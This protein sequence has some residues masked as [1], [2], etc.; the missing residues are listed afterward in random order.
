M[1]NS[2]FY[3]FSSC[4]VESLTACRFFEG[5]MTLTNKFVI[6]YHTFG[7]KQLFQGQISHYVKGP[8]R[9]RS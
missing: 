1:Q 2:K 3:E 4:Q 7:Q 6:G 8:L 9:V 5:K